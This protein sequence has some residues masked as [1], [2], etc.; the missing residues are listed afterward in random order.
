[1]AA[2]ILRCDGVDSKEIGFL[3]YKR[4]TDGANNL[5]TAFPVKP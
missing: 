3:E 5:V 2:L 1:V 4:I